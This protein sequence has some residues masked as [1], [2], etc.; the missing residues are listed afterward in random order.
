M[1]LESE[2]YRA[3]FFKACTENGVFQRGPVLGNQVS[4]NLPKLGLI[5]EGS[6]RLWV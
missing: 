2:N 1:N 6:E 5:S 4:K 3:I